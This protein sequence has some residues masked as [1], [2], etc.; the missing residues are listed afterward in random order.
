MSFFLFSLVLIFAF[1]HFRVSFSS[2]LLFSKPAF[3]FLFFSAPSLGQCFPLVVIPSV[4]LY[5]FFSLLTPA[6]PL[7]RL[8]YLSLFFPLSLCLLP[9]ISS[10]PPSSFIR[11]LTLL[12][13]TLHLL[14]AVVSTGFFSLLPRTHDLP[15]PLSELSLPLPRRLSWS[16]LPANPF[17]QSLDSQSLFASI[18]PP[19]IFLWIS[20][21]VSPSFV[22]WGSFLPSFWYFRLPSYLSPMFCWCFKCNS[23]LWLLSSFS[24]RF[25]FLFPSLSSPPLGVVMPS[26]FCLFFL[27]FLC[28][29]FPTLPPYFFPYHLF[30]SCFTFG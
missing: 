29:Y 14:F 12:L 23:F 5:I 20:F 13:F 26:F 9:Q 16:S 24:S 18:G 6:G 3:W 25:K 4:F 19:A 30:T 17:C 7:Q 8:F 28:C 10:S 22:F 21:R 27:L 15:F 11:S 1:S 2:F